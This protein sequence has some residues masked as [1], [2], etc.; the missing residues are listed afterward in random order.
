[1]LHTPD[2]SPETLDRFSAEGSDLDSQHTLIP[3]EVNPVFKHYASD[4]LQMLG[5]EDFDEILEPIE[6]ARRTCLTMGIPEDSHFKQIYRFNSLSMS[7][8][9]DYKLTSLATYLVTINAN[10]ANA[11]VA[12]AQVYFFLK[13]QSYPG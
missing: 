5:F 7:L 3:F 4:L 2:S 13:H 8:R 11:N 6:R 1:M 9:C 12:R 10:P